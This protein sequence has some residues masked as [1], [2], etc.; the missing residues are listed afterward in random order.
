MIILRQKEYGEVWDKTI[1]WAKHLTPRIPLSKTTGLRILWPGTLVG[2]AIG[3]FIGVCKKLAKLFK[4]ISKNN[5]KINP[6]ND[7]S[8][9][10]EKRFSDVPVHA[11]MGDYL[12]NIPEY[13][14]LLALF[15]YNHEILKTFPEENKKLLWKIFPGYLVVA[16]GEEINGYRK[17][18]M[19]EKSNPGDY[20]EILFMYGNELVFLYDF[21]RKAWYVQDRTYNPKKE[22]KIADGKL[23]DY[24][25]DMFD[26]K[27]DELLKR[28]IDKWKELNSEDNELSSFPEKYL[29]EL[30]RVTTILKNK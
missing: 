19:K 6:S 12:L 7:H 24:I 26:P 30:I 22:W 8:K 13:G 10:V 20:S 21:D 17:D 15:K 29:K 4:H 9:S 23:F 27:N 1:E 14:K 2:A 11:N 5:N 25:L 3:L 18:Y 28:R 16:N